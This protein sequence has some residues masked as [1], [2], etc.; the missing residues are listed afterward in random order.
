ML[1]STK[2]QQILNGQEVQRV[3]I[4]KIKKKQKEFFFG[5]CHIEKYLNFLNKK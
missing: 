5:L 1:N 3:Y 4:E 2:F